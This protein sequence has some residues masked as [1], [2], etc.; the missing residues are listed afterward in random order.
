[1]NTDFSY[2]L[3]NIRT[4]LKRQQSLQQ[5][6]KF[7]Q[8]YR[9]IKWGIIEGAYPK[10]WAIPSTRK[11]AEELG[12]SRT[13][14]IKAY[15]MLVLEKL[16]YS[17]MG[18][19]YHVNYT[20]P[21]NRILTVSK[22]KDYPKL[23]EKGQSFLNH[24][25]STNAAENNFIA[26]KPGLPPMDIFPIKQWKGLINQYW[27]YVKSSDLSFVSSSQNGTLKQQICNFLHV[28][29]NIICHPDQL[30]LVSGSL[31]SIYLV[32]NA[33]LNHGDTVVIED[34]SF[35]NVQSL[36]K[37]SLADILPIALDNE[38]IDINKSLQE[39]A[40]PIK[41]VHVTPTSHY[42]LGVIMSLRRRKE[43]LQWASRNRAYVIENDYEHEIG[44]RIKTY[45]TLFS[46]DTE[47]RTIYLGTFNRLLYPS[48]RLG[49][50]ILPR[51]LIGAVKAIQTHS[52]RIV[53][54][55]TERVMSQFIEQ[56]YLYRYFKNLDI[57]SKE[58]FDIFMKEFPH[59]NEILTLE[60]EDFSSLHVVAS[61]RPDLGVDIENKLCQELL[62]LGISVHPLSQCFLKAEKKYGLII[63]FASVAPVLIKQK[64]HSLNKVLLS[65]QQ[66]D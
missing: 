41:L 50:M 42:P 44:N 34:P 9:A 53:S 26:F 5:K 32:A 22:S 47:D 62:K 3:E 66:L 37:S 2:A 49:F 13:T 8:L 7:K 38:G 57:V 15:E 21:S 27:K 64:L 31:Q 4:A 45:P 51:P 59:E 61:L 35:P 30:V 63:G 65:I 18:A 58:R 12:I 33:V 29:R 20:A 16:I 48:I 55:A 19:G 1:M 25:D 28:S 10:D 43:L 24:F 56:N 60:K 11:L 36:F 17:K 6:S 46:L 40:K 54:H 23:S 39:T 52:H 14:V